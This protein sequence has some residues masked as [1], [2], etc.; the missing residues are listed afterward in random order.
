[1]VSIPVLSAIGNIRAR[2]QTSGLPIVDNAVNEFIR[3]EYPST[4]K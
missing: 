3:D 4:Q 1:M 2:V